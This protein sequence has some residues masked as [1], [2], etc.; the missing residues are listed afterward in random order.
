MRAILLSV[1]F[2]LGILVS[3]VISQA[4]DPS[5]YSYY[6]PGSTPQTDEEI[7]ETF[8]AMFIKDVFLKPAYN[9]TSA[10]GSEGASNQNL[11]IYKEIMMYQ[12][13]K[14]MASKNFLKI[15]LNKQLKSEDL[16]RSA[17]GAKKTYQKR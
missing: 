1:F 6:L 13:A 9:N 15:Q 2:S 14:E 10:F 4:L 8:Q 12:V 11:K 7:V 16:G 5:L 3:P 17:N